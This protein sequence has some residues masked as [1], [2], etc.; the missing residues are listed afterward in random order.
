[1]DRVPDTLDE[2]LTRRAVGAVY[3]PIMDLTDGEVVG[4]ESLARGPRG[5]ALERPDLLF[6]AARREGRVDELDWACRAAAVV[7]AIEKRF[8]PPLTLFVNV[9]PTALTTAAPPQFAPLVDAAATRLRIV[10]EVT[11]RAIAAQPAELLTALSRIRE[12]GWGVAVDDVGAEAHS[13]AIM[14]FLRPDVVKLDLRLVH[15][16]PDP[17]IAATVNAVNAHVERTGAVVLAE[18]IETEEHREIAL[19]LGATLGQGWLLGRPAPLPESPRMGEG[20]PV[21]FLE[22]WTD[23]DHVT[24]WEVVAPERNT[25]VG[26]KRLLTSIARRL[27]AHALD[28]VEEPVVLSCFQEEPFFTEGVR[29]RYATLAHRLP[30]VAAMGVGMAH[31][32]APGVRG[33]ALDPHDPLRSIWAVHVLGPYFSGALIGR[34]LG[35]TGKEHERRFE[36]VLTYQRDLVI[37][38]AQTL[39]RRIAPLP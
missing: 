19:A 33:A 32:P 13:L 9:E 21:R 17:E 28:G 7:G 23:H 16:R 18:G 4:Y 24:P 30:L 5:S 36:F 14:P 25:R 3:Q 15:N 27:E 11:E 34:D 37:R 2:I 6:A 38:S 35:D 20:S 12:L 31:E 29:R 10:V 1:M 8:A 22:P 26:S 39:L